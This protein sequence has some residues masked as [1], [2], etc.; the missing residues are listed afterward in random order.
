MISLNLENKTFGNLTVVRRTGSSRGGSVLWECNCKCGKVIQV[1]TR[2]LNRKNNNIRSCGCSRKTGKQ[3]I[4]WK[5]CEEISG[6]WWAQRVTRKDHKR[7]PIEISI[8]KEYAWNLFIQQERKC[9]LSG[10][11]L[12]ISLEPNIGTASI[13]R[14][15]SSKGYIKGNIQWVHKHIN[16][17]KNKFTQNYFLELCKRIAEYNN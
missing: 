5:G 16:Y 3:H 11:D 2:H 17:M 14:I 9:A 8:T 1:S 10:V 6:A 13:D 15:D 12:V 4:Q 7:V